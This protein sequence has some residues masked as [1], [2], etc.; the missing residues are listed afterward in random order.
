MHAPYGSNPRFIS[1]L[2]LVASL[3]GVAAYGQSSE[4]LDKLLELK[5]SL[6]GG[7]AKEAVI[8]AEGASKGLSYDEAIRQPG[9]MSWMLHDAK[10][11][12]QAAYHGLSGLPPA[13][14]RAQSYLLCSKNAEKEIKRLR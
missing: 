12:F 1:L 14:I 2:L 13:D 8:V 6:C 4:Q 11:V 9:V 3:Q 7:F 5:N 10:P